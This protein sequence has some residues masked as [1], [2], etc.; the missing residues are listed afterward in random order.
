M[1]TIYSLCRLPPTAKR[2]AIGLNPYS[3][4]H[5][6]VNV[7]VD[8]LQIV[9][10]PDPALRRKAR[11]IDNVDAEV[12]SVARRMLELMREARGVGLAGPQV[13]LDWR[14]FVANATGEPADDQVF[15]N[16]RLSNPSEEWGP[17]E[18]G[19]LSIPNVNAEIRRPL[20]ITIEALDIDGKPFTLTSDELPARIWQH[21]TDH[22]DG[23]LILD[24]MNPMDKLACRRTLKQLEG[25]YSV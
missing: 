7:K 5:Y 16:P 6:G 1:P 15:I 19:C 22:L 9:V 14:I 11:P 21:E 23:I 24:R 8:Q 2:F 18:E 13:G 4:Y 17:H 12:Q 10:Y 25:E 3:I 20:G